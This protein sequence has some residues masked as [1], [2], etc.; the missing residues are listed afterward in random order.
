MGSA[1]T[2]EDN[3]RE[4][5]HRHL[6]DNSDWQGMETPAQGSDHPGIR[7]LLASCRR[8]SA[9]R[10]FGGL[11]DLLA[12]EAAQLS[13]ADRAAI[14]LLDRD[15]NELW[16]KVALGSDTILR[17]DAR[18]GVAGAVLQSGKTLNVPDAY[19]DQRFHARMDEETGYKTKDLLAS[20]LKTIDGD[21]IGVFQLLNKQ[22]G[23]FTRADE[24]ML[25]LLADQAAI[26]IQ[27]VQ[28]L[29]EL[30]REKDELAGQNTRLRQEISGRFSTRNMIGNSAA[31]RSVVRLIDQLSNSSVSVLVTGES[32]TGKEMTA[33]ALHYS[34]H[35]AQGPF[36]ALNCAA[37]PE[38]LVESELFG[39][40]KGVATGVGK[41]VGRFESA[42]NGTLF[43]DE[44][45]D[46]SLSSQAKILRVLQDGVLEPVGAGR[47][48]SVDVRVVSATNKDLPREIE[49]GAFRE[50][51]Y[52]R[53][54]VVTIKLPAL[55]EI[56]EDIPVLADHFLRSLSK[57]IGR[58]PPRLAPEALGALTSYRW[59][60][61]IRQLRN[62]LQ[63][64]LA[65]TRR[66]TITAEDIADN[67]RG[68]AASD[69]AK[70]SSTPT[71]TQAVSEL[72]ARMIAESLRRH[73]FNQ[74]QAARSLGLSRQGL[75]NKIKRY[76]ISSVGADGS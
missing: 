69:R 25:E 15:K 34:S 56:R 61:N 18:L 41:R 9:V 3:Q 57:E 7:A 35:R 55:R 44:I 31:I 59:P 45:G 60:G 54:N 19:E 48:V 28:L 26:A 1:A 38:N 21:V 36:E 33:R 67:I 75:I 66:S 20:P 74:A 50:D 52:Y 13:G 2:P 73:D 42:H 5:N 29:D 14:L 11:V 30:K 40:E 65:V 64:L 47:R 49:E 53:L 43:L 23:A 68:S 70:V 51:L 10:D 16:S 6:R 27:N 12:R 17:F 39:I 46:L 37:L 62:E 4:Q 72:E 63:R 24:A 71:L 22:D 76:G 58:R 32:G 8:M